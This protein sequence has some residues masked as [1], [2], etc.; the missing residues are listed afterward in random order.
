MSRSEVIK[1]FFTGFLTLCLVLVSTIISTFKTGVGA[2]IDTA[3]ISICLLKVFHAL[4]K[5]TTALAD[6]FARAFLSCASTI[7]LYFA[8]LFLQGGKVSTKQSFQFVFIAVISAILGIL[9]FSTMTE[10]FSEEQYAFPQLIPRISMISAAESSHE[11]RQKMILSVILSSAYAVV[12]K[13]WKLIPSQMIRLRNSSIF[14]IQNSLLYV[15]TGYFIGY[16][17]WIKM[18]VGFCYS[19]LLFFLH[20]VEDFSE[21]L[22]NPYLYSVILAFSLTN[23]IVAI[24]KAVKKWKLTV[25]CRKQQANKKSKLFG[26]FV[27]VGLCCIYLVSFSMWYPNEKLPIWIFVC[28]I[29]VTVISSMSTAMGVAETGFWFSALDDIVPILLIALLQLRN[30][31]VILLVLTGLTAFEM[32]GIYYTINWRV[33]LNFSIKKEMLTVF[34]IISCM[35]GAILTFGIVIILAK[36]NTI[37]GTELPVPNT[38]VLAMTMDGL[39][40]ALSEFQFPEYLNFTVFFIAC[41]VCLLLLRLKISP[42][43]IIAGLMLP[44]GAFLA[45]GGGALLSYCMRKKENKRMEIF[46]GMAIG[47]SLVSAVTCMIGAFF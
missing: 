35:L 8:V 41:L 36:G 2:V 42:M 12:V 6:C 46:S 29:F 25:P 30:V 7:A 11:K 22:L 18:L 26:I 21:H 13:I 40:S 47:E 9:F 3:L 19:L 32:S 45:L 5:K 23:G 39:I 33:T 28:L 4:S 20:P 1:S 14:L 34:S 24:M 38:K 17:T 37:G 10:Y 44:F 31:D 27:L 16:Q 43:T 15:A